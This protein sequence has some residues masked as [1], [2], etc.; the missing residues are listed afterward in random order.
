MLKL[1]GEEKIPDNA[2]ELSTKI[3]ALASEFYESVGPQS[4]GFNNI[5]PFVF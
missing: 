4:A 2:E 1:S 3:A 5:V